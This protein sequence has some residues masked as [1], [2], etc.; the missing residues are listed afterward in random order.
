MRSGAEK[1]ERLVNELMILSAPTALDSPQESRVP[2]SQIEYFPSL[3]I[4]H[5]REVDPSQ[6]MQI[7]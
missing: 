1:A 7:M 6:I 4:F 5:T 3:S 2:I